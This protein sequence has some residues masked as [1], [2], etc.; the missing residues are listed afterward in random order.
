MAAASA[1]YQETRL[2]YVQQNPI[3]G[4]GGNAAIESAAA[5]V[6]SLLRMMDSRQGAL[7]DADVDSIFRETQNVRWNRAHMLMEAAKKKQAL[8]AL[9]SPIG[10]VVVRML[11]PLLDLES[12]LRP[13]IPTFA[14]GTKL[15][16]LAVPKR[17]RAHPF[18]DE[19]PAKP[20][21]TSLPQFIAA[22]CLGIYGWSSWRGLAA[23]QFGHSANGSSRCAK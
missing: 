22:T 6:N 5:F 10:S 17:P 20:L 3:G 12:G 2:T 21:K 14:G 16:R 18:D 13:A 4:Q 15:E 7:S 23:P 9:E 1:P 19:L 8:T 11:I